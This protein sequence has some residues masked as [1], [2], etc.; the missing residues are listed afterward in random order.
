MC[1]YAYAIL[2]NAIWT[3]GKVL[4]RHERYIQ[5]RDE[6]ITGRYKELR[7]EGTGKLIAYRIIAEELNPP[8]HETTVCRI[9]ERY[10]LNTDQSKYGKK[11]R[12]QFVS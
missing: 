6:H 2:L 3:M 7:Q 10:G 8:V 1:V 9:L 12:S 5:E 4:S 11:R